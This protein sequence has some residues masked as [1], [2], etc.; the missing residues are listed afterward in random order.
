QFQTTFWFDHGVFAYGYHRLY[1]L[2]GAVVS[3]SAPAGDVL[4]WA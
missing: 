1:G 4:G 3:A 2:E